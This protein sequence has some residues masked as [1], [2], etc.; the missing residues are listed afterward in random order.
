MSPDSKMRCWLIFESVV[1]MNILPEALTSTYD[2]NNCGFSRIPTSIPTETTRLYLKGNRF[3]SI[4]RISLTTLT[5][6]ILLDMSRNMLTN[7]EIGSFSGLQIEYLLLSFNRLT[8]VPPIEPLTHTLWLLDLQN[9]RISTV[10]PFTFTNFTRLNKIYLNFNFITSLSD[11]ALHTPGTNLYAVRLYGNELAMLSN[12]A[13]SGMSVLHMRL[14]QNA[15]TR[16]PCLNS[17]RQTVY[18][19][20]RGNPISTVPTGCGQWWGTLQN[21]YLQET[22]LVSLDGITKYTHE[23]RKLIV[24]GSN[25]AISDDTFKHTPHLREIVM[26]KVNRFPLFY[27][28]KSNLVRVVLEGIDIQC[29]EEAWLDGM[30]NLITLELIHTSIYLLPHPGCSNNPLVNCTMHGYFRSLKIMKIYN[31]ELMDFPNLTSLGY[32]SSFHTLSIRE[33]R[34][35]S[36]PCFPE[37]FT[38]YNLTTIDLRANQINYICNVNFAPNIKHLFLS[39]NSLVD[40]MFIESTNVPL[41]NLYH[42]QIESITMESL[43]DSILYVIPNCGKFK[44][45]SNKIKVFPNIKL[46]A[47]A[48]EH[49]ELQANLIPDVP[50]IALDKMEKMIYLNLYDNVITYV[51]PA[52]LTVMPHLTDL[53]LSR[54]RL[55]EISD[56]RIPARMQPTKVALKSNPFRCL[57]TMCWVLFVSPEG[58][59]QLDSQRTMC[60]NS[61]D[62]ERGIVAGLSTECTCKSFDDC[63]KSFISSLL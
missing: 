48:A 40:I 37:N 22:S 10:E 26:K 18:L 49:F 33:S 17:S 12:L 16:F 21:V 13:F 19:Y 31:S 44:M 4:S 32:N 7:V 61:D 50:C 29:I 62:I 11:F 47:S 30:N 52:L 36:V 27:S 9:N 55:L 38:L 51:C 60:T 58:N 20:L 46:I 24:D 43:P 15:L 41:S 3:R 14:N 34:L 53:I 25:I 35:P 39:E 45:A 28:A 23:L 1:L 42:I 63:Q 5:S 59:L 54:N 56:L 8:I 57:Q 2:C 6:A